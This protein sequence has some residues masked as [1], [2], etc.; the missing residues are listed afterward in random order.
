MLGIGVFVA[1][2]LQ[3]VDSVLKQIVLLGSLYFLPLQDSTLG[4]S[5][6]S[7]CTDG[8]SVCRWVLDPKHSGK[9]H[10]SAMYYAT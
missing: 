2:S 6:C 9:L 10:F 4:E 3:S 8:S 5:A 7:Q 1:H